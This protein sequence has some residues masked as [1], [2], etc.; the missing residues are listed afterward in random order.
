MTKWSE[1]QVLR[2]TADI[3]RRPEVRAAISEVLAAELPEIG[4][5][6]QTELYL[7]LPQG[8]K[9]WL[10]FFDDADSPCNALNILPSVIATKAA[11][12]EFVVSR[13]QLSSGTSV[14]PAPGETCVARFAHLR[15]TIF[16]TA[17]NFR[18]FVE[19]NVADYVAAWLTRAARLHADLD[20]NFT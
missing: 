10:I 4:A 18:L 7:V 5:H 12:A 9:D 19:C 11:L 6:S 8:P 13:D 1:P 14:R 17:E 15:A 20:R 2:L 3:A 16:G